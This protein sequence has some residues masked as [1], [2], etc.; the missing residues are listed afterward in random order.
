MRKYKGL[1]VTYMLITTNDLVIRK[2]SM[3]INT[4]QL[5]LLLS[6]TNNH[7]I[8]HSHIRVLCLD[9]NLTLFYCISRLDRMLRG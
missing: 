8:K 1:S 4:Y 6:L 9:L 3:T 5:S 7:E 2:G